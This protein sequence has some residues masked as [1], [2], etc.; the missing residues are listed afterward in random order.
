MG[1]G[2]VAQMSTEMKEQFDANDPAFNDAI[3]KSAPGTAGQEY[4]LSPVHAHG[5][6]T[7]L[8]D[9]HEMTKYV[10]DVD[11]IRCPTFVSYGEGDFAQST[12]KDFYDSL[13]VANKKIVMYRDADGGGG[14]CEGMGP[15]RYYT[16]VFGWLQDL[17]S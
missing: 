6:S 9:A 8:E 3:W 16:D 2:F 11:A 13:K 1:A 15:S 4:W 12:T 14:R 17:W 10:V 7:P 5:L